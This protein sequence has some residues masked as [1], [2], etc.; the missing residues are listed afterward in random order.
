MATPGE[1]PRLPGEAGATASAVRRRVEIQRDKMANL[2]ELS[3]GIAHELNNSIGYISSNLGTLR[4]YTE[5]LLRLVER[6]GANLPPDKQAQWQAQLAEAKWDFVTKDL[7]GLLAETRQGAE[8]LKQL[9]GDLKSLARASPVVE[10]ASLDACVTSA[11][12]ILHH[13]LK[14]RCA[15]QRR[16]AAPLPLA[17]V[18]PQIMQ[19]AVNLIHNAA[20]ALG[21][22][23]GT[24]RLT[25]SVDGGTTSLIVEDSGPGIPEDQRARI[26]IPYFT[27]KPNG[28]GLGL[29]IVEQI[30][31]THGGEIRCDASPELGGARFTVHL[32]GANSSRSET[33]VDL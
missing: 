15:V 12:T 16:L 23:G 13:Q 22:G 17:V 19:M 2:G 4:R 30:V 14:H 1:V 31:R 24:L 29:A 32:R 5:V 6:A 28:T 9:V 3:T 25:T 8:H 11:L 26:F 18:R 20:Q 7:A 27:T 33:Q 21:E 10:N